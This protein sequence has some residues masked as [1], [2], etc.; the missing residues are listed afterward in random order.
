MSKP[1]WGIVMTVREP[2]QLV[3][4][5]VHYHLEKGASEVHV[6]LDDPDDPLGDFLDGVPNCFV[7]RCDALH[8]DRVNRGRRPEKQTR[9][10]S[11]NATSV[12]RGSKLNWLIH[13]D[14]DEFVYQKQPLCEELTFAPTAPGYLA[15]PVRER[16]YLSEQT[17]LFDGA[18]RVPFY[19]R[20]A[21]LAPLYG[22][23]SPFLT[24]GVSGHSAGKS[25]VPVGRDLKFS[26]HAPRTNDGKRLPPL[27]S[28]SSVLLHFDG[29]TRLHWIVKMLRYAVGGPKGL[30]GPHRMAQLAFMEDG[31]QGFSEIA[32]FHDMLKALDP[33]QDARMTALGLVEHLSF[34]IGDAARTAIAD[35]GLSLG[36][37]AFD[38]E[39]KARNQDLLSAFRD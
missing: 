7:H 34:D 24:H 27:H 19:G 32:E 10:Q 1:E 3:L 6:F 25:C 2:V 21:M 36:A 11:V 5:N 12:Y 4:A 9:R 13:L 8:W 26:I 23:L 28:A 16:A 18:F 17:S 35:A 39:L 38:Q 29:L 15:L 22:E 20:D 31:C 30:V 37:A 33:E 14:A